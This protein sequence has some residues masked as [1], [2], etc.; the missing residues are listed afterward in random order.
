[1]LL[2]K[3]ENQSRTIIRSVDVCGVQLNNN[4]SYVVLQCVAQSRHRSQELIG[5]QKRD[6]QKQA[7]LLA[8]FAALQT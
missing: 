2:P 6:Q 4:D 8:K 7:G 1:M 3:V 5:D